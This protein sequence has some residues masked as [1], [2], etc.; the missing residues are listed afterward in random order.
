[1]RLALSL[2]AATCCLLV[3]AALL[4]GFLV[5][6]PNGA[7]SPAP[8]NERIGIIHVHTTAAHGA[9]ALREL[10][11][12]TANLKTVMA[13]AREAGLS[14]VTIT[15]H[16]L[17]PHLTLDDHVPAGLTL[18]LGE[19]VTTRGGHF[20]GLN[21]PD[22]W[23][24]PASL[25]ARQS[26]AS[27]HAAGA[28][29]FLA[30][31]FSNG[32]P[33]REWNTKDFDGIEIWN[34][35]AVWRSNSLLDLFVSAVMYRVN[36]EFALVRLGRT[37]QQNIA[38]W[39][40]LLGDRPVVGICA[41]DAH[42]GIWLGDGMTFRFPGYAPVFRLARQHLLLPPKYAAD[43]GS[44]D[45]GVLLDA[46][47]NGH[48]Y[49]ALDALSP[50]A[51]FIQSVSSAGTVVGPGDSIVW[52]P[53]SLLH[54]ALPRTATLPRI[55]VFHD[56]HKFAEAQGWSLD[57]PLDGPGRYRT[58]VFLRPPGITTWHR[59]SMWILSNPTYVLSS[60]RVLP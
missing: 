28:T 13:A 22:G 16:N 27:A 52:T 39:D 6:L 21:L 18:L 2:L 60:P 1:V 4:D 42:G 50:S 15:D 45:A 44:A 49:C 10:P 38:K 5:H 12:R 33:W 43:P 40:E 54:I 17:L 31:P 35:D 56:G 58:E 24:P 7:T 19:E 47:K 48:S 23:K 36:P 8:P 29:I 51:G 55:E 3:V 59:W 11:H 57:A 26:L 53:G 37:P 25:N 32:A 30:H 20:L 34:D 46:L 41:A 9:A 14:Y